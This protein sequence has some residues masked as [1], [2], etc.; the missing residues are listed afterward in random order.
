MY[1]PVFNRKSGVRVID[2][3]NTVREK[4]NCINPVINE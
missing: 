2:W 4:A 3:Q 1:G